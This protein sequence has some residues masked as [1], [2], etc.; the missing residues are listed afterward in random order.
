MPVLVISVSVAFIIVGL[1]IYML[2]PTEN[3]KQ[4]E[5]GRLMLFAGLLGVTLQLGQILF[6]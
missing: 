2:T 3:T 5:V 1:M 4:A 6:K